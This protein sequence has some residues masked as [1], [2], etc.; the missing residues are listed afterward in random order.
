[1]RELVRHLKAAAFPTI[2]MCGVFYFAHYA[3]HGAYGYG[4]LVSHTHEIAA[5]QAEL[6]ELQRETARLEQRTGLLRSSSIDPDMLDERAR[7]MLGY[8]HPEDLIIP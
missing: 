7:A 6:E 2:C 8:A 4:A 1:M 3:L 5:L